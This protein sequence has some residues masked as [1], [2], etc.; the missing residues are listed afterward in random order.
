MVLVHGISKTIFA[1]RQINK[2]EIIT[3][4]VHHHYAQSITKCK[5][6]FVF[7][8]VFVFLFVSLFVLGQFIPTDAFVV[9]NSKSQIDSD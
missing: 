2:G 3:V 1:K 9:I 8:L 6:W 7:I 4:S 5:A